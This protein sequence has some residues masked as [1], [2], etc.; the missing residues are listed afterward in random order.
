MNNIFFS[1]PKHQTFLIG[2][3]DRLHVGHKLLMDKAIE[4]CIKNDST[5]VILVN[6][7]PN[8]SYN[9]KSIIN[10]F[11]KI[12]EYKYLEFMIEEISK[13]IYAVDDY[14]K[15][16]NIPFQ[17]I[18]LTFEGKE[19]FLK[20]IIST[21]ANFDVVS[22]SDRLNFWTNV[23]ENSINNFKIVKVV[24]FKNNGL[25]ISSTAI[26]NG[27]IK[28]DGSA[29]YSHKVI[30][31]MNHFDEIFMSTPYYNC[32]LEFVYEELKNSTNIL[33]SG[34][35]TGNLVEIFHRYN[36]FPNFYLTEKNSYYLYLAEKK[37]QTQVRYSTDDYSTEIFPDK[38]FDGICSLQNIHF[39]HEYPTYISQLANKL[40]EGGILVISGVYKEET[41]YFISRPKLFKFNR[42]SQCRSRSI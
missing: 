25:K 36:N 13:R 35:R 23:K 38:K 15:D 5:L 20:H 2:T 4:H 32:D 22:T 17:I 19:E 27:Q 30:E 8:K 9:D 12:P 31:Y 7:N 11:K 26:R 1:T 21:P 10:Q 33:Y 39:I 24:D 40:N 3:F 37:F 18:T 16:K 14:L 41:K 6:Q 29:G 42:K 28:S 34:C